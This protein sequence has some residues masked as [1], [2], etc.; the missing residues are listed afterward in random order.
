MTIQERDTEIQLLIYIFIFFIFYFYLFIYL[1][2]YYYYYYYYS[3]I[4]IGIII[5]TFFAQVTNAL[6]MTMR[7]R[8]MLEAVMNMYSRSSCIL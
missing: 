3:Y 7:C 2:I 8:L 1:F 6:R 4:V 5:K